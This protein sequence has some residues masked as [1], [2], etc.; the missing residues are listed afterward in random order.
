MYDYKNCFLTKGEIGCALSHL[1]IYQKMIDENIP[2]AL[3]LED[4]AGFS[5]EFCEILA[6]IDE[7]LSKKDDF[8]LVCLMQL[9]DACFKNLTIKIDKNLRLYKFS[10]GFRTHGYIITKTAAAKL[11][12]LNT[13]IILEA[14]S[15]LQFYELSGL[16]IYTLN[17]DVIFTTDRD[18]TNSSIGTQERL[19]FAKQK[20]I[21]K[22]QRM[23][24]IG[25]VSY[26][27]RRILQRLRN[28]IFTR[29]FTKR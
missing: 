22:K 18:G 26:R 25:G 6:K 24:K 9:E 28:K 29:I 21:A 8:E 16:R 4:D 23:K 2:Y 3:I 1:K 10:S 11:L 14:D 15:W 19:N 12:K 20:F 17:K 27:F 13:P 5:D 7:F